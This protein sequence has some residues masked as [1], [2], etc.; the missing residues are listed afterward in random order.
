[1]EHFYIKNV[2]F[3]KVFMF[4]EIQNSKIQFSE[5]E[6]N[7]NIYSPMHR[8][9]YAEIHIILDGNVRFSTENDQILLKENNAIIF[10]ENK[11]HSAEGNGLSIAFQTKE[12]I[13]EIK[14]LTLPETICKDLYKRI[15]NNESYV[16]YIIFII[17]EF[18]GNI[19]TF[20]CEKD[21][22]YIIS[23]FF[24]RNYDKNIT[25]KD[26][27]NELSLCPMQAQRV[28]KKHTGRTFGENLLFQRMAVVEQLAKTKNL[29]EIAT[30]VG[31][32]SYSG[33]WKAYKKYK[34]KG[35]C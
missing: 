25:I 35:I 4:I 8:H 5:K 34:R 13:E 21:Y 11:F 27:A 7:R 31:Y 17:N 24:S 22:A 19:K 1:M 20:Q 16:N 33:F 2:Y 9:S 18:Y 23:E 15:Q 12:S 3:G 32:N 29:N 28:I 6:I 30:L 14:L 10:P 26:I